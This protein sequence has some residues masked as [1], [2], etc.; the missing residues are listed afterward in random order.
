MVDGSFPTGSRR[1]IELLSGDR[2]LKAP[3]ADSSF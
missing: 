1:E 3:E 2:E